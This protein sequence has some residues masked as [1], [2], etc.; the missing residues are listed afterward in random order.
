[1]CVG[2]WEQGCDQSWDGL[3]TAALHC[4]LL[5]SRISVV[6]AA[7]NQL[8]LAFKYD[9]TIRSVLDDKDLAPLKKYPAA[10]KFF[11]PQKYHKRI[12]PS[13]DGAV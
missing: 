9:Q 13:L 1:M 8:K 6:Q 2:G 5:P 3:Y 11:Q 12:T 4:A 10:S 7:V